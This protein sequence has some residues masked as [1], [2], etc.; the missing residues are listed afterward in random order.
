MRSEGGE[1]DLQWGGAAKMARSK[2]PRAWESADLIVPVL[3]GGAPP[4]S[5][6]SPVLPSVV[7]QM[8]GPFGSAETSDGSRSRMSWTHVAAVEGRRDRAQPFHRIPQ[9]GQNLQ[10]IPLICLATASWSQ[11]V[12][13]VRSVMVPCYQPVLAH[14]RAA[15]RKPNATLDEH[16][17]DAPPPLGHRNFTPVGRCAPRAA[18]HATQDCASTWRARRQGDEVRGPRR[19][20]EVLSLVSMWGAPRRGGKVEIEVPSPGSTWRGASRGPSPASTRWRG[21]EPGVDV[22]SPV[23][24]WRGASRGGEDR[25]AATTCVRTRLASAEGAHRGCEAQ[26]DVEAQVDAARSKST[27]RGPSRRED[28]RIEAQVHGQGP[29]RRGDPHGGEAARR[30]MTWRAPCRGRQARVEMASAASRQRGGRDEVTRRKSSAALRA[31]VPRRGPE[32]RVDVG[33]L[34]LRWQRASRR[35]EP[36]IEVARRK[37]RWRG[38][39]GGG[40][41][42]GIEAGA[43]IA[44][45]MWRAG[46][47]LVL[48]SIWK[49]EGGT[50]EHAVTRAQGQR[51]RTLRKKK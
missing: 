16:N 12:G 36:R 10:Q 7:A 18:A 3:T 44:P 38:T 39:S 25:A 19:G 22:T 13:P 24:T 31:Q 49:G 20:D 1:D 41:E 30:V 40:D 4:S 32:L 28:P 45:S 50:D 14:L 2:P 48:L 9:A 27:R 47:S 26:V 46:P 6:S 35:G 51:V 34:A 11:L 21:G 17:G 8:S 43:T 33:S 23:S 29:C 42:V 15:S 37:W 5:S